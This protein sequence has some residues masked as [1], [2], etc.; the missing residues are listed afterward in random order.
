MQRIF[1]DEGHGQGPFAANPRRTGR[2]SPP[3][4]SREACVGLP[5]GASRS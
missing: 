2:F 3:A 1:D 4:A 5:H